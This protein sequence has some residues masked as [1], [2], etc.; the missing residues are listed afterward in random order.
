M[1]TSNVA[2]IL[3]GRSSDRRAHERFEYTQAIYIEVAGRRRRSESQNIILRCE[4]VDISVGGLK[5]YIQQ[6]IPAGS[7]L[8]LAVPLD[9]GKDNLELTGEAMWV[10]PADNNRGYWV[11]LQLNDSDRETMAKWCRVVHR[12]SDSPS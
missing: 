1:A 4:T 7:Q 10:K 5:L 8:N 9:N 6:A 3:N 12:L 11:G 2:S